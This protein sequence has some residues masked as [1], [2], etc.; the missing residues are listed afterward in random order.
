MNKK[1][2]ERVAAAVGMIETAL[3]ILEEVENEEQEAYDNM[4]DGLRDGDKGSAMSEVIDAI[5]NSRQEIE[6]GK[7][8]LVDVAND[9]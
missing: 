5:Q 4:P 1:R 9:A 6:S 2:R 3:G 8:S 7:D